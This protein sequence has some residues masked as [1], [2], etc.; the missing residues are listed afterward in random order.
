[1]IKSMK[2]DFKRRAVG[3][4]KAV[5]RLT[6]EQVRYTS[7]CSSITISPVLQ[8]REIQTTDKGSTSVQV[9]ITDSSGKEPIECDMIW[10]WTSKIRKPKV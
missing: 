7:L 8:I 4:L 1:M 2:I 10:A 3:D 6:D 5:A 9:A